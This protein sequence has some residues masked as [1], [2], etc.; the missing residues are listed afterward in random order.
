[1]PE[2]E[3]TTDDLGLASLLYASGVRYKGLKKTDGTWRKEM[4]FDRPPI[5]LVAEW[6]SGNATCNALAFWRASRT[7]KHELMQ[8]RTP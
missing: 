7:L 8:V 1:M 6:Q 4:V 5:D 2:A 3:Y